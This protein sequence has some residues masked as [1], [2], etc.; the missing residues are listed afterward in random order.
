LS[1]AGADVVRQALV[2]IA[3][4][5]TLTSDDLAQMSEAQLEIAKK[6]SQLHWEKVID[7]LLL[8]ANAKRTT[9][10]NP[11]QFVEDEDLLD[12]ITRIRANRASKPEQASRRRKL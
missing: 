7:S 4:E 2:D 6:F 10:I 8:E 1:S 11:Q 3:E 5:D 9:L 12:E